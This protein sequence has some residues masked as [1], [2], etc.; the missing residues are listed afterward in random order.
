[1]KRLKS[2]LSAV[3]SVNITIYAWS[4]PEYHTLF[5]SMYSLARA[6]HDAS[7]FD[8]PVDESSSPSFNKAYILYAFQ[9]KKYTYV[10]EKKN[11]IQQYAH[12]NELQLVLARSLEHLKRFD[13]AD[14]CFDFLEKNYPEKIDVMYHV[15]R[16]HIRARRFTAA[17]S[18][19]QVCIEYEK[20]GNACAVFYYIQA[21]IYQILKNYDKAIECLSLCIAVSPRFEQGWFLWAV[22]HEKMEKMVYAEKGYAQFLAIV[23]ADPVIEKKMI[24]LLTQKKQRDSWYDR[25]VQAFFEK[26]YSKALLLLDIAEK[27]EKKYEACALLRI[28]ILVCLERYDDVFVFLKRM[29][30]QEPEN[31]LWLQAAH[32]LFLKT[33]Y[34]QEI[35][36][37]LEEVIR[38]KPKKR[39]LLYALDC[40]LRLSWYPYV[41]RFYKQL[42]SIPDIHLKEQIWYH[43]AAIAYENHDWVQVRKIVEHVTT[44]TEYAPLLNMSAYYYSKYENDQKKAQAFIARA[45]TKD[46][47]NPHFHDTQAY[48]YMKTGRK[49]DARAML[50]KLVHAAPLDKKI[51][52][53]R[54]KAQE[55]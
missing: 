41:V 43:V 16:A 26:E 50:Q 39:L 20:K 5:W 11:Y 23:G 4:V 14:F 55:L 53:H 54:K 40:A 30:I 52:Q 22:L 25:A 15:I 6:S 10:A 19:A 51:R 36:R 31:E 24:S 33:V 44:Q 9:A 21:Q 2:I 28:Q 42:S 8:K 47:Q 1:M 13:E 7:F 17:L 27:N 37:I 46:P 29:I 38:I 12:D 45:L 34:K 18:R 32:A 35:M 48:I 49:K 3:C